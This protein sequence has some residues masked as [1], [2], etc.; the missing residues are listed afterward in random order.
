MQR[1]AICCLALSIVTNGSLAEER[2]A[3][4]FPSFLAMFENSR[5]FQTQHTRFP[6]AT[7]TIDNAIGPEPRTIRHMI[8][9]SSD[10]RYSS[11]IYPSQNDQQAIPLKR[12]I[13]SERG[14]H[15][16]QFNKPD[17]DYSMAYSFRKTGSCWQLVRFDSYSL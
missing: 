7:T 17:T 15:L 2:C 12:S 4:D 10:P 9:N 13:R 14:Q 6:L 16:V 1:R 5:E 11:M 3:P 8:G